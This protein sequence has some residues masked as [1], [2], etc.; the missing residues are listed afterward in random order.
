MGRP[1]FPKN[2]V[3]NKPGSR[4]GPRLGF[5]YR[6]LLGIARPFVM[7]GG[8]RIS[9]YTQPISDWFGSRQNQPSRFGQLLQNSVSNT[10]LSPDGLPNC[11]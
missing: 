8:Y 1:V 9:Y 5:A 11:K 3:Y 10:A 2:F 4:F 6:A 7:R